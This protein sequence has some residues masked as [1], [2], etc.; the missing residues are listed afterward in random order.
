MTHFNIAEMNVA[1]MRHPVRDPRM[2]DF[3]GAIDQVNANA[4]AAPGFLW[5]MPEYL[6]QSDAIEVGGTANLLVNMSLWRDVDSLRSFTYENHDHLVALRRRREWF[7]RTDIPNYVLWWV[8]EGEVPGVA[9][10]RR[11]LAL[12][13]DRGPGP[14]AF[15]FNALQPQPVPGEAASPA[16]LAR[17]GG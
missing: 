7:L 15:T 10:G 4:D 11:R 5:R 17:A 3:F 8:P 9:D 6:E 13:A 16:L 14:D 2:A 1:S 12:L